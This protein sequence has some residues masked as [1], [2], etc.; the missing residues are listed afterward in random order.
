MNEKE[1]A[2]EE[3]GSS[4]ASDNLESEGKPLRGEG[5]E[6]KEESRVSVS[7]KGECQ[8]RGGATDRRERSNSTGRP[9]WAVSKKLHVKEDTE[10]GR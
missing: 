6:F 10:Y 7:E 4:T 2:E 9:E 3:G 8:E 1:K 5:D